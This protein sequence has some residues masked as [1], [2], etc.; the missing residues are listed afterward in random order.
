MQL[1]VLSSQRQTEMLAAEREPIR[2]FR[3]WS[4]QW[5]HWKYALM[6]NKGKKQVTNQ[7]KV[8]HRREVQG[9]E[10]RGEQNWAGKKPCDKHELEDK[11]TLSCS[12]YSARMG[13]CLLTDRIQWTDPMH[14]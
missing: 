4:Y 3:P 9:E 13:Y 8:K 5:K 10:Y 1:A 2:Q 11:E 7:T 12:L 6:L 14:V